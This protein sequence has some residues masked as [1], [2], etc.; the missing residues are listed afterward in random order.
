M[1]LSPTAS[2]W[3]PAH[4]VTTCVHAC[5]VLKPHSLAA[6]LPPMQWRGLHQGS[7]YLEDYYYQVRCSCQSCHVL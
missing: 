4:S 5:P 3:A 1:E 7:P 6:A 2:L